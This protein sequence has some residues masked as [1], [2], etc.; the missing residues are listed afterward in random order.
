MTELVMDLGRPAM[1]GLEVV[2]ECQHPARL[3]WFRYKLLAAVLYYCLVPSRLVQLSRSHS[4]VLLLRPPNELG[5]GVHNH[6]L[7]GRAIL[8]PSL[9]P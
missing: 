1:V 3:S 9:L 6:Q 5:L 8:T 7:G 2:P 4:L